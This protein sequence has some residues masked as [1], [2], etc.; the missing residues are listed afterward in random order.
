MFAALIW[1]PDPIIVQFGGFALR[2]Y[3]LLFATG[4]IISFFIL[5]K[6][7]L[8]EKVSLVVLDKL[9]LYSVVGTILGARLGHCFFYDLEYFSQH[10]LEILLPFKFS[11]EF[12]FVGFR[13]LASHGA[14]LGLLMAYWLLARQTGQTMRWFLDKGALVG[15]L[16]LASIRLGNFMNGEIAGAPTEVSWGMIFPNVDQLPRHPVQLYGF[17]VYLSLFFFMLFYNKKL[18]QRERAVQQGHLLGVFLLILGCL[19]FSME[20]IKRHYV[21]NPNSW[22]NMAQWLSIPL[23]IG[24]AAI[25]WYTLKPVHPSTLEK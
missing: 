24:G 17:V 5:R 11:P 14:L 21:L 20:F 1:N 25:I 2:W 8:E 16:C 22:L 6:Q 18:Q 9:L 12:K 13:G 7:F 4:F 10:P 15:G 19:R 23:I 3:S